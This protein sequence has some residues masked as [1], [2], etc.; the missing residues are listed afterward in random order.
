MTFKDEHCWRLM[1]KQE[2]GGFV[3][4]H[5]NV[6]VRGG[7]ASRQRGLAEGA[8]MWEEN[9]SH[10]AVPMWCVFARNLHENRRCRSH[11]RITNRISP[12]GRLFYLSQF[13][14]CIFFRVSFHLVGRWVCKTLLTELQLSQNEWD[15]KN[16]QTSFQLR[17]LPSSSLPT[18][19]GLFYGHFSRSAC[20]PNHLILC[21]E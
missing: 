14:I 1:E 12:C 4:L 13:L 19:A 3:K 15:D 20:S 6:W 16:V 7:E 9:D 18:M 21:L 8:E 2:E 10:G 11:L 17:G 5:G